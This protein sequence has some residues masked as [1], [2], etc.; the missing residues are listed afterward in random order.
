MKLD[1][2][3]L[4]QAAESHAKAAG[5]PE[6]AAKLFKEWKR[7]YRTDK[8]FRADIENGAR[9][10]RKFLTDIWPKTVRIFLRQQ[11]E[12]GAPA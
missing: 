8:T 4:R 1:V 11:A 10:T 5:A 6:T 7:K 9:G 12:A 3:L 2:M